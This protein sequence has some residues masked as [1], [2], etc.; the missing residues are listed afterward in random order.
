MLSIGKLLRE[1]VIIDKR[2]VNHGDKDLDRIKDRSI[3]QD[4]RKG[5]ERKDEEIKEGG[6]EIKE[7]K[8]KKRE[9][10]EILKCHYGERNAPFFKKSK[11]TLVLLK[12]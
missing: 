5:R 3:N 1:L 8:T 10:L 7:E 12:K 2:G 11:M 4:K 9:N 6:E